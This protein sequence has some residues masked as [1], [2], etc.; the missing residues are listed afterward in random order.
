M[1]SATELSEPGSFIQSQ[2]MAASETKSQHTVI[3]FRRRVHMRIIRY[4]IYQPPLT[5][6]LLLEFILTQRSFQRIRSERPARQ[7]RFARLSWLALINNRV[8]LLRKIK[9]IRCREVTVLLTDSAQNR[10]AP[11]NDDK[12][13]LNLPTALGENLYIN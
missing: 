3:I 7:R 10:T 11:I 4:S 13:V 9:S 12:S 2:P 6:K 5:S 8:S 1:P